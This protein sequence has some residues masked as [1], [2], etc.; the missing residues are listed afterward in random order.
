LGLYSSTLQLIGSMTGYGI[1]RNM[2]AA[3]G[4]HYSAAPTFPTAPVSYVSWYSALRFA[5][6]VNNGEG[7]GS[8]ESGAYTLLGNSP[9]P[10][11]AGSITRT[12]GATVF[13][14]S[15]NE[16][17]KAAYYNPVTNS[18]FQY[19]TSS[20]VAPTASTPSALPNHAMYNQVSIIPTRVG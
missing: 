20:N 14:P 3:D 18:Y 13:L 17:Y 2:A 12:P 16:W 8:T 10:T 15:E 19:G 7:N 1:F 9:T 4:S 11:N 5:N 6:W